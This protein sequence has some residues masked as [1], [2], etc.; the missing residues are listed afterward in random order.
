MELVKELVETVILTGRIKNVRSVSLM[1]IAKPEC[2]K[3]SVV[4]ERPCSA[5][6]ILT[7]ITGRGIQLLCDQCPDA[8]HFVINDM[9]APS[10]KKQSVKTFTISML[11]ALTEEGIVAVAYPDGM[12][13][14]ENGKRAVICSIPSTVAGDGR[15]WWNKSGF[16]SRVVPFAFSH[17]VP[18]VIRVKGSIV[19]GSLKV[20]HEREPTE[21]EIPADPVSVKITKKQADTVQQIATVV[22]NG[23]EEIG[24][25]RLK[26]FLGLAKAHAL[27][28]SLRN[29]AVSQKDIEFLYR[30]VP[31]ISYTECQP[32]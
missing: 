11:S 15:A 31:F 25:R 17:N 21:F 12:R 24:Y 9:I 26:Q 1:L 14:F 6:E 32:L 16:A 29:R 13:K 18:M 3:T 30:I 8:T 5:L 7:D 4:M 28:R 20:E 22:S 27:H 19:N 10:A 23:L 2:G